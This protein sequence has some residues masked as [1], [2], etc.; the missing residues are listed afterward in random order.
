MWRCGGG[1]G[2]VRW[3]LGCC[4]GGSCCGYG[5]GDL[6]EEEEEALFLGLQLLE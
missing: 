6:E 5:V 4:G 1:S 2:G 3:S